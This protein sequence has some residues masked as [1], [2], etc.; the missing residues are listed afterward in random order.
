M[1]KIKPLVGI[2]VFFIAIILLAA[3]SNQ[4]FVE[5]ITSDYLYGFEVAANLIH[6]KTIAGQNFPAAPY[7]FPDIVIIML[8]EAVTHNI[9]LLHFLYSFL[10]LML[11]IFL[12]YN[13]IKECGVTKKLSILG[14]LIALVAGF[15][16]ISPGF[17]FLRDWPLSHLMVLLLSLFFLQYYLRYR[18]Q[19]D[20]SL[21]RCI[22]LF[23]FLYLSYVSD[24]LLFVQFMFPFSM[25]IL[26]DLYLKKTNK[27]FAVSLLII[28]FLVFLLGA[29]IADSLAHY[30][31]ASFSLNVS[32]YRLRKMEQ[33]GNTLSNMLYIFADNIHKNP[34]FYGMLALYNGV[35]IVLTAILYKKTKIG[36]YFEN[37]VRVLGFLWLAQISNIILA[38]LVG[39]FSE[40][41]HLRYLDTIYFFPSISL[42][43]VISLL[44]NKNLYVK[45]LF[46][47]IMVL[48][49]S[50]ISLFFY[51]NFT[52]LE[53]FNLAVPYNNSVQCIDALQSKYLIKN[54]LAEYWHVRVVRM[55]SKKGLMISQIDN[56]MNFINLIDNRN[57]FWLDVKKKIPFVYQFIIVNDLP[58]D[59]IQQVIGQ[60]DKVVF[61]PKLEV[62]LYVKPASMAKLNNYFIPKLVSIK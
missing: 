49:F 54:G 39:K 17:P 29:K 31:D 18:Q 9:S 47:F 10:F 12:V 8:L 55:L 53:K 22:I 50:C 38:L 1:K 25:I 6:N 45:S 44:L 48:F 28:F 40:P 59:K 46:I 15:F 30:F 3:A 27:K 14:A 58:K 60:P 20:F 42:A 43:L 19:S 57:F 34:V 52:L 21:F 33:L 7:F 51:N 4:F 2:M 5:Y 24:N 37:G 26:L 11:Y 62:W 36:L 41:A 35:S 56:H 23:I 32:L 16:I 61:C 13:L